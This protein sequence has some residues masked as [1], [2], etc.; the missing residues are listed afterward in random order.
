MSLNA[1]FYTQGLD[2]GGGLVVSKAHLL[3]RSI[4]VRIPLKSAFFCQKLLGKTKIGP[5]I[6]S[7]IKYE[8]QKQL[9]LKIILDRLLPYTI[10]V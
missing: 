2:R 8:T 4:L 3:L 5:P 9:L 6:K 10:L 1:K 7:N